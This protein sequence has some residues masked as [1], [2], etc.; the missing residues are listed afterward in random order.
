MVEMG[1]QR[2]IFCVNEHNVTCARSAA[3]THHWSLIST[4]K[5]GGG[6]ILYRLIRYYKLFLKFQLLQYSFHTMKIG[7]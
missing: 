4:L 6:G 5:A 7:N 3:R 1:A 2:P